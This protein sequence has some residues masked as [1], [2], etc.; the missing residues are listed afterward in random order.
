M[1][2]SNKKKYSTHNAVTCDL[3]MF[4]GQWSF[5]EMTMKISCSSDEENQACTA[6]N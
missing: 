6:L 3:Q 2:T 1:V 4:F 5:M